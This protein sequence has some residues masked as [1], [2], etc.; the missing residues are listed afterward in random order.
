MKRFC[1]YLVVIVVS[2]IW[3]SN[4]PLNNTCTVNCTKAVIEPSR[5]PE[6][7]IVYLSFECKSRRFKALAVNL[8]HGSYRKMYPGKMFKETVVEEEAE[9]PPDNSCS[10]VSGASYLE[11]NRRRYGFQLSS[12]PI[13]K[14]IRETK[15]ISALLSRYTR[16]EM[17]RLPGL[18]F[19]VN[20]IG[21]AFR[22]RFTCFCCTTG[23]PLIVICLHL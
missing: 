17:D 7:I 22:Y 23:V 14:D 4:S 18:L 6:A 8:F 5:Q 1:S 11:L 19:R 12:W 21:I 20:A 10:N 3:F 9:R 2:K 15:F 16:T 13:Y